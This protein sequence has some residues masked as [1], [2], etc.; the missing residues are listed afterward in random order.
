MLTLP[1]DEVH[2]YLADP[3]ALEHPALVGEY[4]R[5]LAPEE[6]T[7]HDRF[8][9]PEHRHHYLVTRAL[10]RTTLSRYA[11]APP[12]AWTFQA[13]SHGRPELTGPVAQD[14]LCFNLSNTDGLVACVVAH[15]R[16]V[17]VDVEAMDRNANA[18]GV[19]ERFFAPAEVAALKAL[20][21]AAQHRRFFQYWTLKE[22]YIKARGLGLSIPLDQ[23]AFRIADQITVE[24]DPQLGDDGPSWQF[25]QLFPTER[26]GAAVA[27]RR[28]RDAPLKIITRWARPLDE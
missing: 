21:E 27:I 10:A 23:F 28:G 26:H 24:C 18:P 5:L 19:A 4:L 7:R 17:G 3:Y 14:W 11:D 1:R 9:F 2:L 20:P 6:R 12:E 25:E 22:S 13:G 8:R 15:A 16:E